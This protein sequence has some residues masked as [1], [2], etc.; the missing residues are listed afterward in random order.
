M[1]LVDTSVWI[2][3]L[4]AGEPALAGALET[5]LVL[6]HPFVIGELA[7]GNLGNRGEI[8]ARLAALPSAPQATHAEVLHLIDAHRLMGRG[9]GYVDAHLLAASLL[10]LD[11]R[12]WT[13]DQRLAGLARELGVDHMA[14]QPPSQP[15]PGVRDVALGHGGG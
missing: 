1:I 8:L 5:G 7:C 4:R 6:T 2:D 13:R 9:I 15:P 10:A 14:E 11:A 12:L 3:F